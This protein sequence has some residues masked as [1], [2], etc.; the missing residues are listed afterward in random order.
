MNNAADNVIYHFKIDHD[1]EKLLKESGSARYNAINERNLE[2]YK[3][4]RLIGKNDGVTYNVED[5]EWFN[6]QT[7][8]KISSKV[9]HSP[10]TEVNRLHKIFK[11]ALE[12][13]NLEPR[14]LTQKQGTDAHYHIDGDLGGAINILVRGKQTPI[15][16]KDV[17]EFYYDVA[18][19]NANHLHAVPKQIGEDRVLFKLRI[20]QMTFNEARERL[21]AKNF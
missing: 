5:K 18:L 10:G 17:G 3:K 4:L 19:I 9:D 8:W 16:F 20:N 6:N 11:D 1:K 7:D 21:I 15:S 14:F 12:V 2:R 13:D